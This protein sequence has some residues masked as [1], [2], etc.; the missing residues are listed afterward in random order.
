MSVFICR[1][2][3]KQFEP[4]FLSD[5]LCEECAAGVLDKYHQVREYLWEHPGS[6]AS[7]IA[8]ACDCSIHDVMI[9]VKEDRFM[10]S[11]DSKVSLFCENCGTKIYSGR[12]CAKCQAEMEKRAALEKKNE[13]TLKHINQM[14]GT[15]VRPKADDGQ[16]RFFNNDKK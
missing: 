5:G 9:W 4:Q 16:M 8:K 14:Q 15:V 11:K 13:K 7:T 10:V 1:K 12:Y 3:G 6:T 2:C